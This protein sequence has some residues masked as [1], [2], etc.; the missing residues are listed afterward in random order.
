M[1]NEQTEIHMTATPLKY[2]K[3]TLVSTAA[4]SLNFAAETTS[5]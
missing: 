2:Y 5:G 3:F 4:S 1:K